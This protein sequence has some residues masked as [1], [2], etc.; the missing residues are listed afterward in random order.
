M[1]KLK[2]K[3]IIM[4]AAL[5]LSGLFAYSQEALWGE[6]EIISPEIH[7]N[8]EVTFRLSAPKAGEVVVM[9]DWMPSEN[10]VPGTVAMEKDEK[11]IWSYTTDVLEPELYSYAFMVDGVRVNDPNNAYLSRD[12]SSNTNIFIINGLPAD[13]YK[14]NDVAHGS[15]VRRWYDSPGLEM[16]R[17]ITIY[18]P[19]GYEKS[20]GKY[21][22]L[23]L[24]H[25]AGGDEEAWMELGRSTQIMDN[26]IA[27]G[28][29]RPMIVVMPNGN[30]SQQAAP[31]E[32]IRGYYK[33]QLKRRGT[34]SER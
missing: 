19:P 18:T 3:A 31:G 16:N 34:N 14:V 12:I 11:G 24:L 26:L 5:S 32:G 10:W 7:T 33:P 1:Q 6:N 8:K 13:L 21:P 15:V 23:Y 9:G 29:A 2:K 22:V 4:V 25:G 30:V 28:K 20:K 27:H 17:R